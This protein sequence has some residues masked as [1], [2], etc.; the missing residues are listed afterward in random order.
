MAKQLIEI[1]ARY[2]K[3]E[4][5]IFNFKTRRVQKIEYVQADNYNSVRGPD[6]IFVSYGLESNVADN[7]K[8]DS[9]VLIL[10]D[11]DKIQIAEQKNIQ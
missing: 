10:I 6:N 5:L 11:A 4:D 3:S 1:N 9:K 7:F 2:L 8:P